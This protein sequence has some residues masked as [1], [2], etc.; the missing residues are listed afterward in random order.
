LTTWITK[1]NETLEEYALEQTRIFFYPKTTL[2]SMQ[3]YVENGGTDYLSAEQSFLVTLHVKYAI[4]NDPDIREKLRALTVTVLDQ[5][6]GEQVIN[7]TEAREELRL[8][9]GD[10]VDAL[11]I[12]GLG[13][14]RDYQL[15]RV[16]S[17]RNKLCLKKNLAIQ[18]DKTMIVLDAVEVEFKL[19]AI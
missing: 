1:N 3:V 14:T 4:Y 5:Y 17:A 18:A 6:V 13:G 9:Y 12:T 11:S 19:S 7:M 15:V 8:L 16:A 2:G 10:A